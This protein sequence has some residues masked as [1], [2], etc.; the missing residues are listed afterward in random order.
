MVIKYLSVIFSIMILSCNTI[1]DK[2]NADGTTAS[3]EEIMA[4]E[5]KMMEEGFKKG[6]IVY[7]DVEGDCPYTIK[8][9][10]ESAYFLDPIN[11]EEAFRKDGEKIWFK[12][13]GLR[14]MNRCEKANPVSIETMQKRAE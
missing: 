10:G 14:R 7:S 1:K 2:K 5:K 13:N 9:E 8:M 3:N 11:L 6:V 12:F 4:E